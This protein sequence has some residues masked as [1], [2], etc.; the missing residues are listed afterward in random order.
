MTDVIVVGGG[1]VGACTAWQIAER[2]ANVLLLERGR[3]AGG[4]T[5]RSQ[6]LLLDP[7][8]AAMQPLFEESNRLYDEL[9]E[10]SGIDVS[11][12]REPVGTLYVAIDDTQLEPLR[13]G[14]YGDGELL[15]R[16][17]VLEAEPA[18]S[19]TVA[20]GLRLPGG[21]RSDPAA[22][23]AAAA[24]LA[25]R[26]GATVRT[27]VDVK[28][29]A[30]GS[31]LTDGGVERAATVVL[32]AGAWTRPLARTAGFEVPIRPVRGWLAVTAPAEPLVRHVLYEAGYTPPSGPQPGEPVSMA[33]LAAGDL[34]VFG[35]RSATAVAIHQAAD[36][37]LMIGASRSSALREGDESAQAL[38]ENAA[39]ACRLVPALAAVEVATTWTGLRPFT[40]DGLP[41]IGRLDDGLV[42][43]AGHG[44]E[45]ILT[46]SGSAR[47]AADIALRTAPY[48]D[49]SP[50][51][52]GRS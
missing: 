20:G 36:G 47:L 48:T 24:E 32:A 31:V 8:H 9:A 6:G 37:T 16:A 17:G 43:C 42:I 12:D 35:A 7:D 49:P 52:P 18:L 5:C 51:H 13:S 38:R 28:R 21:R 40:P 3:L 46:G 41:F 30:G 14:E 15:D 50:F 44:S 19:P 11:L 10:R 2:G 27:G 34:A 33:D 23:T 45:G 25:R 26:A 29:L 22:L 4:A 1:I 39:R